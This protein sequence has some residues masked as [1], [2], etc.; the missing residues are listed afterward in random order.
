VADLRRNHYTVVNEYVDDAVID[1][2]PGRELNTASHIVL[3]F[4]DW[5]HGSLVNLPADEARARIL[6]HESQVRGIGVGINLNPG[7]TEAS[8]RIVETLRAFT[9]GGF[10]A[11]ARMWNFSFV[12]QEK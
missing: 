11:F 1:S 5:H 8:L 9:H 3:S 2:H 12:T 7:D 4:Q 6:A 10:S